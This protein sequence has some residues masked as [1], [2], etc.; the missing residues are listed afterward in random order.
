M[1]GQEIPDQILSLTVYLL[2]MAIRFPSPVSS[3]IDSSSLP[4]PNEV[5]DLNFSEWFPSNWIMSS[6]ITPVKSVKLPERRPSMDG[7]VEEMEVDEESSDSP[8][9]DEYMSDEDEQP[10]EVH[11]PATSEAGE[12]RSLESS[13]QRPQ[14]PTVSVPLALLPPP[15]SATVA[16]GAVSSAV[17]PMLRSRQV[18]STTSQMGAH[19]SNSRQN[20]IYPNSRPPLVSTES[21]ETANDMSVVASSAGPARLR[22][23]NHR[24]RPVR[25]SDQR[26]LLISR[27]RQGRVFCESDNQSNQIELSSAQNRPNPHLVVSE[28]MKA[29]PPSTGTVL[30]INETIISLLVRLHS[31]LSGK[32]DSYKPSKNEPLV[33]SRIGDGPFF[34]EQ[35]LNQFIQ[36]NINGEEIIE[37]IRNRIWRKP[38]DSSTN[39]ERGGAQNEELDREERRRRARE[40]QQRLMAE[41]KSKQN[42]F[43]KNIEKEINSNDGD[44]QTTQSSDFSSTDSCPSLLQSKEYECVICGQTGPT[45]N[46]QLF[47]QVVLLQST[48]VLGH[49]TVDCATNKLKLPNSEE[50]VMVLQRRSTLAKCM[51]DRIDVLDQHFDKNS[52]LNSINIGWVGGVHVQSCGHYL[53]IDCHKS[54]MQSLRGVQQVQNR[55]GIEQ[56]EYSCPLCRQ[57]ANSVLP[58]NP[59]MGEVGAI[60][61][62]RPNDINAV[63]TEILD[64]LSNVSPPDSEFLKSLGTAIEDL[65]KAT[66]PQF[67]NIRT[68]PSHQSL[69]LFLC[70]IARTNLE[71]DLLLEKSKSIPCGAKKSCFGESFNNY[72]V[73]KSNK[74]VVLLLFSAF[75]SCFGTECKSCY[76]HCL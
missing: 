12:T 67:R 13:V 58:I 42:A 49:S 17:V 69:F 37:E 61:K 74:S 56:G 20:P 2:D 76:I 31:K 51:E 62:C 70:S 34:I 64:L 24:L 14:L 16:A 52:W 59:T 26:M 73:L 63:A 53:H 10:Y 8:E 50:E 38:N 32:P 55:F 71:S 66:G 72:S 35:F 25:Q 23:R 41:F 21:M 75:V 47:G 3:N 43:M 46:I 6:L 40:R 44:E 9:E 57:M 22:S 60:V 33:D 68:T 19:A 5:N 30:P 54:Y 36:L 4:A 29:L 65:T 15:N 7:A 45:S 11:S 28:L 48:S 39:E 18:L 27:R 1:F